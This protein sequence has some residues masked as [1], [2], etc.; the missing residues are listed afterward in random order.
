MPGLVPRP[1]SW[2]APSPVLGSPAHWARGTAAYTTLVVGAV[3]YPT[4]GL[5]MWEN[6]LRGTPV[7]QFLA[8]LPQV[9]GTPV[10][11]AAVFGGLVGVVQPALVDRLRGRLPLPVLMLG[12]SAVG[13]ALGVSIF[14]ASTLLAL[15]WPHSSFWTLNL[16][17][18]A[19]SAVIGAW[20][21]LVWWLP[22][23]VA[24]VTGG[25]T[26]HITVAAALSVFPTLVTLAC[27]LTYLSTFL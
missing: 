8:G 22:F 3:W 1:R 18:A 12:Q 5:L 10:L 17:L 19:C 21:A 23:T 14:G 25:R 24:T 2:L 7:S 20:A 13:G 9:L 15:G 4:F 6:G 26:G 11:V 27:L 16:V